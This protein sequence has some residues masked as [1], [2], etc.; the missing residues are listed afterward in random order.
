MLICSSWED[1][2][3]ILCDRVI[4]GYNRD[5]KLVSL[6]NGTIV[7]FDLPDSLP[8]SSADIFVNAMGA[9]YSDSYG[10]GLGVWSLQLDSHTVIEGDRK[11]KT[12]VVLRVAHRGGGT[13]TL[14]RFSTGSLPY[15]NYMG[16]Q[17][18]FAAHVSYEPLSNLLPGGHYHVQ[19]WI[20]D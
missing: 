4:T 9:S 15:A 6:D 14:A 17:D 18:V 13:S 8:D 7:H 16:D 19:D 3:G 10:V 20:D 2:E 1:L 11:L 5:T 12:A